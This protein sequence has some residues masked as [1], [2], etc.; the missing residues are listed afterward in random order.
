MNNIVIRIY[1]PIAA[2]A[3]VEVDGQFTQCLGEFAYIESAA[4]EL[5]GRGSLFV[6]DC[7]FGSPDGV[8]RYKVIWGHGAGTPN[9]LYLEKVEASLSER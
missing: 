4:H 3:Y 9:Y 2:V 5:K 1:P 8:P 6:E 7:L